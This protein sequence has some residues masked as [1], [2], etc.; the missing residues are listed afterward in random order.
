ML[1]K[2][3]ATTSLSAR[4]GRRYLSEATADGA[5]VARPIRKIVSPQEREALRLARR[6]R[7]ARVLEQQGM[8]EAAASGSVGSSSGGLLSPKHSRWVWYIG[9]GVPCGLLGWGVGDENSPP[10][11]L[12]EMI[13]LTALIQS[14]S[15]DF[16]KP[17]HEKLLPDWSQASFVWLNKSVRWRSHSVC[18]LT[19]H[20]LCLFTPPKD[21][22]RST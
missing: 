2:I 1:S 13:G 22:K 19:F 10:A 16:A 6:E 14:F 17:S 21:A 4:I 11:K 12:S 9:I 15:E 20:L 5:S 7:A 8:G 3:I 18:A